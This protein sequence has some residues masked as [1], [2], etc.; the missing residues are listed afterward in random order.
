MKLKSD[1]H[2]MEYEAEQMVLLF[3][4][5]HDNI[6]LKSSLSEK[7]GTTFVTTEAT[8]HGETVTY[9]EKAETKAFSK[10]ELGNLIKRSA[11]FALRPLSPLPAPWGI[12][13]GVRPAKLVRILMEEGNSEKEVRRIL[14]ETYLAYDD[15]IDLAVKVALEEGKHPRNPKDVCVYIGI[16]YCPT[17]CAY[18]SFIS[19]T[20]ATTKKEEYVR[21]LLLEIQRTGE[22]IK[23]LGLSLRS[24][25]IGG[26]TPTSLEAPLLRTLHEGITKFLPVYSGMEFTTEAG[27]PDTITREKL[28]V[29][30]AFGTNRISINPQTLHDETLKRI[31]R[32]HTSAQFLSAFALA[33]EEGFTNVNTDLIAGLPGENFEM[34]RHSFDTVKSLAPESIT[35]H[36]LYVKRASEIGQSGEDVSLYPQVSDMLAYTYREASAVGYRPYYMYRQKATVG[37]LENVGYALPGYD[38][39]YNTVTMTDCA[40][41][42]ALGAGGVSRLLLPDKVERVFN[43]KHD[44]GY[45]R[46][47]AEVLRRKEEFYKIKA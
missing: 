1:G 3:F 38:S 16:P 7:D 12:L 39:F 47:F 34:Y 44:D 37:N 18:C 46:E 28:Q 25:Y 2:S 4:P 27:R 40:N 35:V 45:T 24:I 31:G 13:T 6:T 20:G 30:K 11:Y 43:F 15:K 8:A 22:I 5:N 32:R 19:G 21:L 23:D 29:L 26:G 14:K 33:R 36:T 17:R 41:I 42:F 9:T 10:R